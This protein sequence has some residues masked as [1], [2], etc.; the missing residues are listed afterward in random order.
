MLRVQPWRALVFGDNA[1]LS[2]AYRYSSTRL[3]QGKPV[4]K[5]WQISSHG[6]CR[7]TFGIVSAGNLSPSGYKRVFISGHHFYVHRLV[8][9]AFLGRAPDPLAWQVHHRDGNPCN[10]LVENLEYV[11][12]R[13]NILQSYEKPSRGNSGPS[14]SQP[15]MWRPVG[16]LEWR[17]C[18][19]IT[20]AA[21]ETGLSRTSVRRSCLGRIS[22][23]GLEFCQVNLGQDEHLPGEVWRPM[24]DPKS[25]HEIP[26]R[27]VSSLGRLHF[28]SG[29]RS[30]GYKSKAGYLTTWC[31]GRI[32]S[33]HRLV[34][35]A[36]LGPPPTLQRNHINHKDHDKG[37]N[38][39]ENLEYTTPSENALH[40]LTKAASRQAGS[41]VKPVA[42]RLNGSQDEW[43]Q[44]RSISSAA[45]A[46]GLKPGS[47][48][49]WAHRGGSHKGKFEFRFAEDPSAPTRPGEEWRNVDIAAHLDERL[50]RKLSTCSVS[51]KTAAGLLD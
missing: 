40:G 9:F 14:L 10:N 24:H 22:I 12:P 20:A 8:A 5:S 37:N 42:S 33:V 38:A 13:Q 7:N 48:T 45:R 16:S 18:S 31:G 19:S 30:V 11:T 39:V 6:R 32:E 41:N 3:L 51:I 49:R 2:L 36:F 23:K 25:G 17:T 4:E 28:P 43:T 46:C 35:F 15:V 21:L 44:H 50:H 29:R 47:V 26:R 1:W 34:A 27:M